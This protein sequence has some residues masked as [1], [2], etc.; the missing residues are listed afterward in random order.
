MLTGNGSKCTPVQQLFAIT[1][2]LVDRVAIERYG[3]NFQPLPKQCYVRTFFR[4]A[5]RAL[6]FAGRLPWLAFFS[7]WCGLVIVNW[8]REAVAMFRQFAAGF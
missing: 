6:A 1:E 4:F 7:L 5:L 8:S 2:L 3:S